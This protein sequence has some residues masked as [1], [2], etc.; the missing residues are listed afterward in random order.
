MKRL[1]FACIWEA[2]PRRTWSYTPWDLR[3]ALR[4]RSDVEIV[5]I[6]FDVPSWLKRVLQLA[7]LRRRAGRWVTPWKYLRIWETAI[8]RELDRRA[9]KL[10]CDAVLQI[11]DLGTT[12]VPSLIYQD[13]S[14]DVILDCLEKGSGALREY[15]PHLDAVAV[16][17]LRARQTAIYH[18]AARLLTMSN[19]L[20]DSLIQRTGIEPDKIVTVWPGVSLPIESDGDD[21]RRRPR[22]RL[23]FV[24]TSFVVKGGD[25][26]LAALSLLRDKRPEIRLTIVGPARWPLAT[27]VPEGV[28]FVGRIDPAELPDFYRGHDLM[29]L[30]SRLEGFGKVFV[31]ALSYGLPCIGRRAFAMPELIKPGING[32]LI[33]RDDPGDLAARIQAVLDD[34]AVYGNCQA[35]KANIRSEFNW[36]RA[37]EKVVAATAAAIAERSAHLR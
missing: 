19:F 25:L 18:R 15:F 3:E 9:V 8:E 20:R 7:S 23:L 12:S 11:Q 17:R 29:V 31:E 37:A 5:D 35:A 24:G 2:E 4:R 16:D 22:H 34:D 13:F 14:Y 33:E 1:G 28:D 32:D 10:K 21:V 27:A 26:V 6:G 36:D 30:P